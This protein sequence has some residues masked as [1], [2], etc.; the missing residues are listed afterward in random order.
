MIYIFLSLIKNSHISMDK[1]FER[2]K[3]SRRSADSFIRALCM[4]RLIPAIK[5]D[6]AKIKIQRFKIDYLFLHKTSLIL[7][8]NI[9]VL[10]NL[11]CIKTCNNVIKTE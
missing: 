8:M 1:I 10:Y 3:C 5:A 11:A 6:R 7:I 9:D 4:S 2:Y